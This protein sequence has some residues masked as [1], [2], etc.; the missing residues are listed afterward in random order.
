MTGVM[1]RSAANL[2]AGASTRLSTILHSV[3]IALFVVFAPE[4]LSTIPLS[5]LAA[6]LILTG[7]KL[8]NLKHMISEV[9]TSPSQAWLWPVTAAAVVSTD[10]LKGLVIGIVL[11]FTQGITQRYLPKFAARFSKQPDK[12][13]VEEVK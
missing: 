12:T 2:D 7:V 9:N 5:A 1:V 8:I 3:W 6:V 13:P 10:L 11:A 4:V